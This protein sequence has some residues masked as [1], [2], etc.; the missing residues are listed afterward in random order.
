MILSSGDALKL[1]ND[2]PCN[3]LLQVGSKI[4]EVQQKLGMD[5]GLSSIENLIMMNYAVTADATGN[6]IM[7]TATFACEVIDV[8][9]Q[10]RATSGGGT[11]LIQKGTSAI[12]DAI[13]CAVDTTMVRAGTINDANS[14]LAIGNTLNVD[15]NGAADRGLITVILRRL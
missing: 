3:Q 12:T 5:E 8:I 6:P 4:L 11:L 2:N 7:W 15:A 14:T 13:V 9:V 1:N 10:A